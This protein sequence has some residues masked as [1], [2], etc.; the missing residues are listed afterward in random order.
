MTFKRLSNIKDNKN[1]H[2]ICPF[3]QLKLFD[4]VVDGPSLTIGKINAVVNG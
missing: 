3:I 1:F 2:V 4:T